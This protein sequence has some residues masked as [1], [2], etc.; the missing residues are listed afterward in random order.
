MV[1]KGEGKGSY[2]AAYKEVEHGASGQFAKNCD[3]PN[4][5]NAFAEAAL[6]SLSCSWYF[7]VCRNCCISG[8]PKYPRTR[9]MGES[10]REPQIHL[11]SPQSML[12]VPGGVAFVGTSGC[13]GMLHITRFIQMSMVG[14]VGK[15]HSRLPPVPPPARTD[16]DSWCR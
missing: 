9:G 4:R 10:R 7:F 11:L 8:M 12:H 14:L 1:W 2:S 15:D 16:D 6:E 3:V 5:S 13:L